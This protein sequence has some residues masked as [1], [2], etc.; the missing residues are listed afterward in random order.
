MYMYN[1]VI[2]D[3]GVLTPAAV[4]SAIA[5]SGCLHCPV[6][7]GTA[8]VLDNFAEYTVQ[9]SMGMQ[10]AREQILKRG[11]RISEVRISEVPLHTQPILAR[12]TQ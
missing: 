4:A 2:C 12:A 7:F 1:H 9:L 11:V 6:T 10:S 5:E 3:V 8:R